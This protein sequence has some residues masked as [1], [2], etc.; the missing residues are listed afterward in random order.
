LIKDPNAK[1]EIARWISRLADV[2]RH[3]TEEP[4]TPSK[5]SDLADLLGADFPSSSFT[6]EALYAVARGNEWFPAYDAIRTRMAE[7]AAAKVPPVRHLPEPDPIIGVRLSQMDHAWIAYWHKNLPEK[8]AQEDRLGTAFLQT[9]DVSQHPVAHLAS[10]IRA[11]SPRGWDAI[12]D[13]ENAPRWAC[14]GV[15][16]LAKRYGTSRQTIMRARGAA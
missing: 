16:A 1:R 13:A 5:L 8:R 2:C 15:A 12:V 7:L 6:T 9:M 4:M 10:L 3:P 11:Q 14:E